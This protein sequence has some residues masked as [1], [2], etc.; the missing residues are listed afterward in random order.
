MHPLR[1]ALCFGT[2]P[3]ER[4]GGSDFVANLARALG[5]LEV[6]VLV[7]TSAG[8]GPLWE[9]EGRIRVYRGVEDWSTTR[10][11]GEANR[12][13]RMLDENAIEILHVLFPDS[14]LQERF[15]LP[16]VL[17]RRRA[18]VTTFWNLGL[19]RHSPMKLRLQA[20]RLLIAS[21]VWT[22]HD[23]RY[24]RLLKRLSGGARPVRWLPVGTNV[25]VD[26]NTPADL[27]Q[28]R[29]RLGLAEGPKYLA[30]FGQLD[31]TRGVEDL[32]EAVRLLRAERD[33]RL[34]MIGSAGRPERYD[35]NATSRSAYEHY[36]S[37]PARLGIANAVTWTA[38]LSD[39]AVVDHLVAADLCVL[40]YR[41][42]SVGRSALATALTLGRATVLGGHIETITPLQS[43]VHVQ[44]AP[45]A[46]P[47]AL[48]EAI[49]AAL[50]DPERRAALERGARDAA[51]LFSWSR[52]AQA[53]VTVYREALQNP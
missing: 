41:R 11:G 35:L 19:G 10:G 38:Y 32:F 28:A 5:R 1:I 7:L 29:R 53:A 36:T 44:L 39:D 16:A 37:L 12:I 18:L 24:L 21:R 22:S 46:D 45:P 17:A 9:E 33:I 27:T 34:L 20:V 47:P 4:N 30:Y 49:A 13:I 51:R 31:A 40:P 2:Y 15:R 48:A 14:V 42:T 3:P 23:P 43:G 50:D 25:R 8:N 6:E 52:I 26:A